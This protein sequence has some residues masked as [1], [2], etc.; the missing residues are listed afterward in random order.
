MRS[1]TL[2]TA[3]ITFVAACGVATAGA[4]GVG[5]P[6]VDEMTVASDYRSEQD[7]PSFQAIGPD[8]T[9][10][11]VWSYSRGLESD[12]AISYAIGRTW[13]VPV[14]LGQQNGMLDLDPRISFTADGTPVVVWWQRS[15]DE[16]GSKRAVVSW[17]VDGVWTAPVPLNAGRPASYPFPYPTP[18]SPSGL[19][20]GYTID[21]GSLGSEDIPEEPPPGAGADPMPNG[22]AEGPEPIPTISVRD[23]QKRKRRDHY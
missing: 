6:R 8:G 17:Y 20:V 9:L 13:T 10:W 15:L 7:G 18:R 19:G 4:P 16:P 3:L 12:L 22:G 2:R 5:G 1:R 11:A 14:L 21:D 23:P